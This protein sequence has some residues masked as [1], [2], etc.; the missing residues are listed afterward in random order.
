MNQPSP[1]QHCILWAFSSE[2]GHVVLQQL[3][4]ELF[5]P[6][7][8]AEIERLRKEKNPSQDFSE[9]IARKFLSDQ[10]LAY[11]AREALKSQKNGSF[12]GYQRAA[13]ILDSCS[14]LLEPLPVVDY[15]EAIP[16]VREVIPTR[17]RKIDQQI[18]GLARKELGFI[19]APSG[20]GK[21]R[22][23]IN[24]A[25]NA[26]RG[27]YSVN[28][29]TVADQ[30]TVEL[31]P[32]FDTCI[33]G[34]AAMWGSQINAELLRTRH[35]EAW[36]QLKGKLKIIDFTDRECHLKD[37]ERVIREHS[38]DLLI[39][40]HA[41]D[42]VSPFS[43][44]PAVTRH[45][46]RHIYLS[47]KGLAVKHKI[48]IWTASQSHDG[49]WYKRQVSQEE[50]AEAKLGKATG[51]SIILGFSGGPNPIDGV[52]YCT[53]VKARRNYTERNFTLNIDSEKMSIW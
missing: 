51:A 10:L 21:T 40:D 53:I 27:G 44:D 5:S 14:L 12:E 15:D 33:L 26:L 13:N 28:Y 45:S 23:L 47:L 31:I 17:I 22:F 24:F 6:V 2:Q 1:E 38:S 8:L 52:I 43:S 39:V 49:S 29:I 42:I 11:V 46:L 20:K 16:D 18:Q 25:V 19:F 50:L 4:T 32:R 35:Q 48:P 34:Y 3:P 9:L 41:D 37:I 36:P 7:G 30:D